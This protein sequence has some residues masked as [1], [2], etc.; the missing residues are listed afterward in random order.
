MAADTPGGATTQSS[1][2]FSTMSG[3]PLWFAGSLLAISNFVVVLDTT[4]TNVSVP[5]IAGGLAVSPSQGTWVITSYA[6]AEAIMVPLSG[7][8]AQRFGAVRL[9][10]ASMIGFGIC[11]ALC[12][13]APSL[14]FLVLFRV[15][16]GVCGG[17][18]M[19]LSQTLL[20]RIFPQQLQSA[21][22][23][24]WAMTTVVAPIAGPLLGGVLVD[25]MGWPWI[26]FVN[27]PVAMIVAVLVWRTLATHETATQRI[28]VDFTGLALLIT[29]VGAMQIMLDKGKDLDW[30]DSPFIVTLAVIAL[31]GFVAFLIWELTDAHPVVDLRVFR[32][33]GFAVSAVVMSI[34]F[35][36]FF[37]TVVL[38]PLWL[39][40]NLGYT[41]TWAGRAAAFQ[42]VLAVVMSPVV[43]RLTMTRDSRL[44]VCIGVLI[45]GLATLW[46]STFT[47]DTDF[48]RIVLPQLAQGFA[49]PFFFIPL[50]SVALGS[51]LPRETTSAAGLLTFMRST[52]AAFAT[53]ITTTN[54]E[55][56]AT[57]RRGDLAGALNGGQA[58]LD[59]LTR[60]GATAGQALREL[61]ALV[62]TQAVMLA[63][64]R[65]FF[66]TSFVF[67]LAAAAIWVAPRGRRAAAAAGAGH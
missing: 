51:V 55:N 59:T 44:L 10:V 38:L 49:I 37:S 15:L 9:F 36:S 25:G 43:A 30:F 26:F 22:L 32:H 60:A 48:V 67:V 35:G 28:P 62:Q 66:V 1:S 57:A 7:W 29:W 50:M 19:P 3:A 40:T 12:G 21:A 14:G 54:W 8:L 17:P 58:M 53:S 34:A 65:V 46:R 45:F 61:D 64:D 52:A 63:T 20:R 27:V 16:Q 6:V 5:N 24:L 2:D 13:L 4:I 47:T 18:M 11:S 33:R 42:G 41:A 23:G 39:Q 31:I 56:I